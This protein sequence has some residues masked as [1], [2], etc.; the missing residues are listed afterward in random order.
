MKIVFLIAAY[1]KHNYDNYDRLDYMII[2]EKVR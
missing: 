1:S 2:F